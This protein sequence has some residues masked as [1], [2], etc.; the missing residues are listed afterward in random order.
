MGRSEIR[1]SGVERQ[2]CNDQP[3]TGSKPLRS[4]LPE[5]HTLQRKLSSTSFFLEVGDAIDA[6]GQAR[7]SLEFELDSSTRAELA[8]EFNRSLEDGGG[9]G[10]EVLER[11]PSR[12][13]GVPD[14]ALVCPSPI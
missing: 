2:S 8:F 6:D 3:P 5:R 10:R 12:T 11:A 9:S 1:S 14:D 7:S 13:N 4:N